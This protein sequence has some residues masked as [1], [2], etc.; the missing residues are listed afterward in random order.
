LAP[1]S[2]KQVDTT[3]STLPY[4]VTHLSLTPQPVARGETAVV[5]LRLVEPVDCRVRYLDRVEAC[6]GPVPDGGAGKLYY[7]LI[8]L[9]P[10]LEVGAYTVTLEIDAPPTTSL[11]LPLSLVAS[12]GRYDYERLDLPSDRQSLLDP[13]R[14]Q[15]ERE[16][17]AALRTLRSPT[18]HWD[19]PFIPPLEGSITS[20]YGS[21]RSY[22][23]GFGSFHA[24]A[25]YRAEVGDPVA[26]PAAGVVVLAEPLV[27]RGNAVLVDHGWG[28]VSGYWHLSRLDVTVGQTL[29]AG[30]LIGAVGNTGLSTGPHLH[31]ELW[32]N[33]VAV[34]PLSWTDPEGPPAV[35]G[36]P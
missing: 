36:V 27:V 22:G 9:P 29:A 23:Y 32:V 30:D 35:L 10:L 5:E 1:V 17:I 33:G 15:Q 4:P 21:R 11:T 7:A 13:A 8:G 18:R 34:N 20:F 31:W 25:D 6:H 26:V 2:S 3:L 24:G 12:A 16:K 28:V 19:Y 14:S